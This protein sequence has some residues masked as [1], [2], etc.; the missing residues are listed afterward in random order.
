M[1]FELKFVPKAKK[2]WKKLAPTIKAQFIKKL[3]E[4][5]ENP[6]IPADKL[7]GYSNTYK[8]KLRSVGYR[9]VYEVI[10]ETVVV[11]VLAVGRRENDEVYQLLATRKVEPDGEK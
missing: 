11:Y 2:E 5:L 10:D 4:R 7:S 8:I 3:A 6:H 9:L 1:T